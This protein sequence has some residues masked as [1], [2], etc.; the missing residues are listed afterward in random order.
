[1]SVRSEMNGRAYVTGNGTFDGLD[2]SHP[3]FLSVL[4]P[5]VVVFAGSATTGAAS[6]LAALPRLLPVRL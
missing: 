4:P 3:R 5:T 2:G 6:A 1:V